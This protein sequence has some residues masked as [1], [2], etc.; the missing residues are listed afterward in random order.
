MNCPVCFNGAAS[1]DTVRQSINLG[2]FVLM[3]VTG[4]V[5]AGFLRFI[6]QIVRRSKDGP[7]EAGHYNDFG[8]VRLQADHDVTSA[9]S[10]SASVVSAS[11]VSAFRRTTA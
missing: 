2:I 8:S 5:L 7:A 1:D 10:V 9:D 4:V 11:V 3:G 6:I